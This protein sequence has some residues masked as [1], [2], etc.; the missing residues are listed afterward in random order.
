MAI[1]RSKPLSEITFY[2][3]TCCS[4][5]KG[6]PSRIDDAPDLTH[7]PFIYH[8]ECPHCGVECEQ[9]GWEKGLMK[10]WANATGP[11]TEEG[12]AATTAN[13]EGHPT[14]E[15][16]Q[17]TRFNAMKHGLSARTATY[18]PAKPDGYA[19][20]ATCDVDRYF[21]ASQ[22]ACVKKTELFMLH[23]AAFEQRNPK[24]LMGI[25]SDLQASV[26]AVVQ[27]IIQTIVGDGVKIEAPQWFADKETGRIIIAEYTDENGDRKIIKDIRDH[28]PD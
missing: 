14:K 1:D 22:P 12:K 25:Y 4:T 15:E 16:A 9:V 26:L 3:Q 19:F 8:G 17:R 13:L 11:R 5:F 27:Q 2:C 6:Q 28:E 24:H 21:C 20:C 10:A 18:F 23:H 7:H